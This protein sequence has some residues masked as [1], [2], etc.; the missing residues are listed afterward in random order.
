M[1]EPLFKLSFSLNSVVG[2]ANDLKKKKKKKIKID[3]F[4]LDLLQKFETVPSE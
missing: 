1:I 2:R 3:Y 4:A